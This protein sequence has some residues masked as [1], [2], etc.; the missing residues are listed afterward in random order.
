ML[1]RCS[2]N[3]LN[4]P[5]IKT[6]LPVYQGQADG[7]LPNKTADLEI[8]LVYLIKVELEIPE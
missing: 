4:I 5:S 7:D 2:Q 8:K 1:S 6:R 3:K